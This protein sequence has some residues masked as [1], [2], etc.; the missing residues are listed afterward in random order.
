M[1]LY[2]RLQFNCSRRSTDR[3]HP[4]GGCDVGS[5]PAGSTMHE[6]TCPCGRFFRLVLPSRAPARSAGRNR[7]PERDQFYLA[8]IGL[9]KWKYFCGDVSRARRTARRCPDKCLRRQT[10]SRG[11]FLPG[12]QC[13]RKPAPVAGFLGLCSRAERLRAHG[14]HSCIPVRALRE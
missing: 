6:K 12:A 8:V 13:T 4:C 14:M 9:V 1:R 5:I 11:S 2:V 7:T 10:F 3:M